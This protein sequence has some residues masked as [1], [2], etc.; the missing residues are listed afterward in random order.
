M[1]PPPRLLVTDEAGRLLALQ[2]AKDVSRGDHARPVIVSNEVAL[3]ASW[4][5]EEPSFVELDRQTACLRVACAYLT[6]SR[7]N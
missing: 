1:I 5:P 6:V 2:S 4:V 7:E 3:V